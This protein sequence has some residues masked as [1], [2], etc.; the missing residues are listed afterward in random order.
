MP[1]LFVCASALLCDEREQDLV[2][3]GG[4]CPVEAVGATL[5]DVKFCAGDEGG[6][7][8]A[9]R[10]DGQDLVRVAVEDEGRDF[11]LSD[12]GAEVFQPRV[13]AIKHG[14]IA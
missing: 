1:G 14:V 6:G 5:D 3:F 11:D 7:A 12:V 13:H 9:G 10:V 2:D 8:L 4:V